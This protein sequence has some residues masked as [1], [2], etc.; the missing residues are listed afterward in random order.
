MTSNPYITQHYGSSMEL[1]SAFPE[2]G[3]VEEVSAAD[4]FRRFPNAAHMTHTVFRPKNAPPVASSL[5]PTNGTSNVVRADVSDVFASLRLHRGVLIDN[6]PSRPLTPRGNSSLN[7]L[8]PLLPAGHSRVGTKDGARDGG[9]GLLRSWVKTS[10]PSNSSASSSSTFA[11]SAAEGHDAVTAP[12]GSSV[13]PAAPETEEE[14]RAKP[15]DNFTKNG[16]RAS[17]PRLPATATAMPRVVPP[18]DPLV[19]PTAPSV[20]ISPMSLPV[21]NTAKDTPTNGTPASTPEPESEAVGGMMDE[22][23]QR[24]RDALAHVQR[25]LGETPELSGA[26]GAA[27][28]AIAAATRALAPPPPLSL[29]ERRADAVEKAPQL[30]TLPTVTVEVAAPVPVSS[31]EGSPVDSLNYVSPMSVT[32]EERNFPNCAKVGGMLKLSELR[33]ATHGT[34]MAALDKARFMVLCKVADPAVMVAQRLRR[35]NLDGQSKVLGLTSTSTSQ[36][37]EYRP[38]TVDPFPAQRGVRTSSRQKIAEVS[39]RPVAV[40]AA[41]A[42][43]PAE[44]QLE[45]DPIPVSSASS[46]VHAAALVSTQPRKTSPPPIPSARHAEGGGPHSSLHEDPSRLQELADFLRAGNVSGF[47][48]LSAALSKPTAA[49]TTPPSTSPRTRVEPHLRRRSSSRVAAPPPAPTVLLGNPPAATTSPPSSQLNRSFTPSSQLA[50]VNT[51][52][53]AAASVSPHRLSVRSQ[54][55]SA[56]PS[57][58][59]PTISWLSKGS[60]ASADDFPVT[61]AASTRTGSANESKAM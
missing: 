36:L 5:P 27:T 56:L 43:L 26:A 13:L 9:E 22:V 1:M 55:P 8:P 53:A 19:D 58:A 25:V 29:Q 4:G 59:Q 47:S 41:P 49:V 48:N 44:A 46:S 34:G 23:L 60:E 54:R 16:V 30:A 17:P 18:P 32:H 2:E 57:Y 10:G 20:S 33:G 11:S 28:T 50:R 3:A 45:A 15:T 31:K 61:H 6:F 51:H 39:H 14:G 42:E 35:R 52:E 21:G 7:S 37:C 40:V 38:S 12:T 24:S